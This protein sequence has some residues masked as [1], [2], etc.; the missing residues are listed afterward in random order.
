MIAAS[1]PVEFIPYG[2]TVVGRHWGG[3][4]GGAEGSLLHRLTACAIRDDGLP[5][6][7]AEQWLLRDVRHPSTNETLKEYFYEGTKTGPG[8]RAMDVDPNPCDF[9]CNGA[10]HAHH[11]QNYLGIKS[12]TICVFT[13]LNPETEC[14]YEEELYVKGRTVVWSKGLLSG[15]SGRTDD[16]HTL[17]CL[18]CD[19]SIRHALFCDFH[20][21]VENDMLLDAL[22]AQHGPATPF[23][24][25]RT[26]ERVPGCRLPSLALI[27]DGGLRTLAT[28]GREYVTALPFR[29]RRAWAS[30]HGLLL[31]KDAAPADAQRLFPLVPS[32][33]TSR[34]Y[35]AD[36]TFFGGDSARLTSTSTAVG[37]DPPLPIC[38]SL[39]HPLDE[40]VP[41]LMKSSVR[42]LH[43]FDDTDLRIVFVASDPSIALVYDRRLNVHSLWRIR[44]ATREE[45]LAVCPDVNSSVTL[46]SHSCDTGVGSRLGRSTG[47]MRG[48]GTRLATE[49]LSPRTRTD[50][51]LAR[52]FR[53]QGL[54]PHA[55]VGQASYISETAP[56]GP[57]ALP[58]YPRVC[59]DHVWTESQTTAQDPPESGAFLHT[60]LVGREYLC[61]PTNAS[62]LQMVQLQRIHADGGIMVDMTVSLPARHAV[63]L[64][65]LAMFA[66]IDEAGNIILRSGSELVGKIHVGGVLARL[67]DSPYSRRGVLS[68][69]FPRRSSLLPSHVADAPSL[70]DSALHLLSP[71]P[72]AP[73]ARVAP[74]DNRTSGLS[75]GL[76]MLRDAAGM[77]LT[78]RADGGPY[79]R[80]ALPAWAG[81]ALVP[82]CLAAL[83]A[84]LPA[85]VAVRLLIEWYG[86][87]NAPGMRDASSC[88]EWTM[89]AELVYSRLGRDPR[90]LVAVPHRHAPAPHIDTR[91]P[92]KKQRTSDD[93]TDDDWHRLLAS[94]LHTTFGDRLAAGLRLTPVPP[95]SPTVDSQP[96]H[97]AATVDH[98][99][100]LYFHTIHILY[101]FHLLYEDIKLNTLLAEELRPLAVFL[102]KIACDVGADEY[103]WHYW[104]DFPA[105]CG[106][107]TR[108]EDTERPPWPKFVERHPP[109]IFAQIRA[110]LDDASHPAYPY[111]FTVNTLSRDIIESYLNYVKVN[112]MT[113]LQAAYCATRGVAG[114]V[115]CAFESMAADT[116][117][118]IVLGDAD[119][120]AAAA[121]TVLL[122]CNR[123]ITLRHIDALPPAVALLF[124]EVFG[125]C[126]SA[127]PPD[128]PAAA[129]QLVQRDDLARAA[130]AAS[131]DELG[132]ET[133]YTMCKGSDNAPAAPPAPTPASAAPT[134]TGTAQPDDNERYAATGMEHLDTRL[135]RLLYP[136][137]HRSREAF[138]LLQSSQP[139]TIELTQRPEVSDH[140]FIEEQEKHLYA[141]STRTTAL[142]LGRGMVTL[143]TA[144]VVPTESARVPVLCVAGRGPPPR[145]SAVE[146]PADAAHATRWPA[147]HNGVAAGLALVPHPSAASSSIRASWVLYNRPKSTPATAVVPDVSTEHAGFLM[148]VGLNGHLKDMP[149]MNIYEYLVKCHEMTSVGLLLGLAATYRG[150]MDAQATKMMSIH[151]EPMLPP[152]AVE[153]DIQHNI[154]VAALFGVGLLYEGT[155]HAHYAHVLLH[156]IGKPPGPEME[157]CVEREGYALAAGLALGFVCVGAHATM[158]S[159]LSRTLR[160]YMVGGARRPSPVRRQPRAPAWAV[161][162]GGALNVDVT[163]PG[164]TLALGLLHLGSADPVVAAWLA[165]PSTARLLNHVRPDLLMLRIIARGLVLWDRIEPEEEW[166][167]AQVPNYI[168]EHCF[169]EPTDERIDYEAVNQ[170]YCN[171]IAG[172]C[173]CIG[174]RYA[175]SGNEE[176]RDALLHYARLLLR[177]GGRSVAE[178]AGRATLESCLCAVVLAAAMVMAGRGDVPVMRLVR[179]L[180]AR[181]PHTPAPHHPLTHGGQMAVHCALGL[182][183]LGNGRCTLGTSRTAIAAL[184]TAFFPKFPT[185][186]EDNRYHLQALRHIYVL[187]TEPRLLL[188]REIHT[189][190]LCAAKLQLVELDGAVREAR[191]PCLLPE[192]SRLREVRLQDSRYWSLVFKRGSNWHLLRS[193]LEQSRCVDVK[194]RVG[195]LSHADDPDGLVSLRRQTLTVHTVG[196]W[197]AAARDFH[198][199]A[200]DPLARRIARHYLYTTV[201]DLRER[202]LA[203]RLAAL[204]YECLATEAP[205]VLPATLT[206]IK[207]MEALDTRLSTYQVWQLKLLFA[208][209]ERRRGTCA[210]AAGDELALSLRQGACALLDRWERD[211]QPLLDEWVRGGVP[212]ALPQLLHR[213]SAYALYYDIPRAASSP[214]HP[215]AALLEANMPAQLVSL[216]MAR[217][218]ISSQ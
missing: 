50:S 206:F 12:A 66:L 37:C 77:R 161:R 45:C 175:G 70:D 41:V 47:Q 44:P 42:G 87:R 89:F 155:G 214:S 52:A 210:P 143:R 205:A 54:S 168:R 4:A 75:P 36:R 138:A 128:W 120:V 140:E 117:V 158:P 173:F 213:L 106:D 64:S 192:L 1:E 164:A 135:S 34:N 71:V 27:T 105:E 154:L 110:I 98:S 31:E 85:D 80:I 163:A 6:D 100:P 171:I 150:T 49:T 92:P 19:T 9:E 94:P 141:V 199:L 198:L 5:D 58:L 182:L 15:G 193:F 107:S 13:P 187:A 38:F 102:H 93:G 81:G 151:L 137:D 201:P 146:L 14:H 63:S 132:A 126:R 178:L 55:S 190:R 22:E 73:A 90:R 57:P 159:Q 72:H 65:R 125:R 69:P 95:P 156:E 7:D 136:R 103:A 211:L 139:V 23:R 123:G 74:E 82:R 127:P 218:A 148:G 2:R 104:T 174:L 144:P 46:F 60:D 24:I 180:R 133:A 39:A 56:C 108:I 129:Y 96:P 200:V 172:A 51:P 188:L 208:A 185:H 32:A 177:L 11:P 166:V 84:V 10:N 181:L 79:Y 116:A 162:E 68:S 30:A 115:R 21:G 118:P 61:Y 83:A 215:L 142:P 130:S 216:A 114:G 186:S 67:I 203:D 202:R 145:C 121:A 113:K 176:A 167:E 35:T 97:A 170:A 101:A 76:A 124:A 195:C 78:L 40:V 189:G 48:L 184:L 191:A 20:D 153:L 53:Q 134:A 204:T 209:A 149:F 131:D 152:T 119:A 86:V 212:V 179:R 183:F 59:F 88:R 194:Q 147:F 29:V 109:S 43:Y 91:A 25:R 17:A 196:V 16:R 122:L 8:T 99:A 197:A 217:A 18:T 165:P 112:L 111:L 3:N 160:H 157:N 26:P 207:I 169:V 33:L 62:R 28:D